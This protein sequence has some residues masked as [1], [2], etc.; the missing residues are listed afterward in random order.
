MKKTISLIMV[1]S[2]ILA[3]GGLFA[4]CDNGKTEE[5]AVSTTYGGDFSTS[6][7]KI[8]AIYI[9]SQNDKA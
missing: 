5:S 7:I 4:S 9:T 2:M 1:I 3:F 8:G 6:D